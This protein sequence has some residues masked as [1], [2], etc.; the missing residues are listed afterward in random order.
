M[1][2]MP[3]THPPAYTITH[4]QTHSTHTHTH[5]HTH[6]TLPPRA[7]VAVDILRMSIY[8][9]RLF[10]DVEPYGSRLLMTPRSEEQ[11]DDE[12]GSRANT[13]KQCI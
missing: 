6:K 12:E 5:T 9:Y 11:T 7:H 2:R 10:K 3:L 4:T 1:L 13:A 8:G